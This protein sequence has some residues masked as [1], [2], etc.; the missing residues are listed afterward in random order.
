MRHRV[1]SASL[2]AALETAVAGDARRW[3]ALTVRAN[4]AYDAKRW[5]DAESL[6]LQAL[7]EADKVFDA[8]CAGQPVEN[9]DPAPMLVVAT[10]N[11]AECWLTGGRPDRAGDRLV[12]LCRRL[13]AVVGSAETQPDVRDQ[14]FRHLRPLVAELVDKLSRA[15]WPQERIEREVEQ[16]RAVALRYLARDTTKH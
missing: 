11:L 9:A 13:C 7:A 3:K 15:G 16:I 14:C 8:W 1:S 6:Y 4:E 10:A 12:A 5:Q 2:T